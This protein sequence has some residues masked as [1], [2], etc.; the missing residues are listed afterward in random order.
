MM[1][2]TIPQ[3]RHNCGLIKK[4]LD[5]KIVNLGVNGLKDDRRVIDYPNMESNASLLDG[6]IVLVSRAF[7]LGFLV[8]DHELNTAIIDSRQGHY[9]NR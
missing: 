7:P 8:D 4:S 1:K 9:S 2:I 6:D 5:K 3:N